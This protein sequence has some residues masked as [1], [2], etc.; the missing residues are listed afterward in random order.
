MIRLLYSLAAEYQND[1]K[2]DRDEMA[3]IYDNRRVFEYHGLN[4]NISLTIINTAMKRY[5][6]ASY[7]H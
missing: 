1:L 7:C 4:K 2:L 5:C 3:G 6:N